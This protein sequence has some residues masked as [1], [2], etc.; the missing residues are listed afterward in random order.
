VAQNSQKDV[1]KCLAVNLTLNLT[2]INTRSQAVV[3]ITDRTATQ[4]TLV[5]SDCC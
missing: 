2:Y 4:Q 1:Q 5:I 3:R